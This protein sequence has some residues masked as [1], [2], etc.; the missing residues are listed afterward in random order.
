MVK[1][2]IR[3]AGEDPEK[4][5]T[6][7]ALSRPNRTYVTGSSAEEE[8]VQTLYGVLRD[9]MRRDLLDVKNSQNTV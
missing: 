3:A 8:Q 9:L 7:E 2:M 1:T 6:R 4:W 5:L